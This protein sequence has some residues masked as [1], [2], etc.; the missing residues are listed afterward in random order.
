MPVSGLVG[1]EPQQQQ[2]RAHLREM[3]GGRVQG[4]CITGPPG[5]GK[6]ALAEWFVGEARAAGVVT[7]WTKTWELGGAPP[8][9]P[10]AQMLRT[11]AD[12]LPE[13]ATSA[14]ARLAELAHL[15]PEWG[16][17]GAELPSPER[18]PHA[19]FALFDAVSRCIADLAD[20]SPLLLVLDDAHAA[21]PETLRV[22][23][24]ALSSWQQRP[25]GFV[26]TLRSVDARTPAASLA[27]L[28]ELERHCA[29][30]VVGPLA[31]EAAADLFEARLG[32]RREQVDH[33]GDLVARAGGNPLFILGL[34][35]AAATGADASSLPRTVQTVI[36]RRL[37]ALPEATRVALGLLALIRDGA[38]CSW[39]AGSLAETEAGL[40]ARL[41]P[42]IA[43]EVVRVD[44]EGR[45]GFVHDLFAEAMSVRTPSE[46]RRSLA[47]AAAAAWERLGPEH[48]GNY[49]G[50]LA[51]LNFEVGEPRHVTRGVEHA[52]HGATQ[53]AH[54]L[55]FAAAAELYDA[56]VRHMPRG[57]DKRGAQLEL[58]RMALR[59]GR[60]A[61]AREVFEVL[62]DEARDA[63]EIER[64][65]RA[66]LGFAR[67]FEFGAA[68]EARLARLQA[69]LDVVDDT[70]LEAALVS[71]LAFGVQP[72]GQEAQR[73]RESLLG[74]ARALSRG[75][76][77][78]AD[79]LEATVARFVIEWSATRL[80]ARVEMIREVEALLP[81]LREASARLTAHRWRVNLWLERGAGLEA[82]AAI[83]DYSA[84]AE[85]LRS[86]QVRMNAAL[87]RAIVLQLAGQ[88][89]PLE[90]ELDALDRLGRLARD[91]Q[92]ETYVAL[93]RVLRNRE[94]ED[95]DAAERDL[96]AVAA[97]SRWWGEFAG[98]GLFGAVVRLWSGRVSE[99]RAEYERWRR[100]DFA[101]P[102]YW[103]LVQ[104]LA[105]LAELALGLDDLDGAAKIYARLLPFASH[106]AQCGIG[107]PLG[108]AAHHLGRIA[109]AR[110]D[111]GVAVGHF[112][113]AV[114][115]NE[116]M[117]ADYW[118][119]QS[120]LELVRARARARG[121]GAAIADGVDRG[122]VRRVWREAQTLGWT[123][124][125][126]FAEQLAEAL[127]VELGDPATGASPPTPRALTSTTPAGAG[128]RAS[129][130]RT[131]VFRRDG[132]VWVVGLDGEATRVTDAR[133]LA[134]LHVLLR[135]P[136][137]ER[138]A[139]D[140]AFP[141]GAPASGDAGPLLDA[142]ARAAYRERAQDLQATLREAEAHDDWARAERAQA[143][144]EALTDE[145]TRAVGR[146][147]RERK[148]G[149]TAERARVAVTQAIRRA[150]KTLGRHAPGLA[151]HLEASVRTGSVCTYQPEILVDWET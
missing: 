132:Q 140:L 124:T 97:S 88:F 144:L 103:C 3:L 48:R 135:E 59:A 83:R 27:P 13:A 72:R 6:S 34:A 145:L 108:S 54:A 67:S 94:L 7:V 28:A 4:V 8:F 142:R 15:V 26:A 37:D 98:P 58:G 70:G 41:R 73:M 105:L 77:S 96:L 133:G 57:P 110:G 87:R 71:E 112:E 11:L 80:D 141:E 19:Q 82:R 38:T 76:S 123:R 93:G 23:A 81:E 62:I 14:R 69:A 35:D 39:L 56:A 102:D 16:S 99:A 114:A 42:A 61:F 118:V 131:G 45:V 32:R 125:V 148:A 101:L 24:Y 66:S 18:G 21:D 31:P 130:G 113:Q 25:I 138:L 75:G 10:W 51:R 134:Y 40:L 111:A 121:P 43:D 107:F 146:G 106:Q 104:G 127:A 74:R 5:I 55:D 64:M 137:R 128:P 22:A 147:G 47:A 117:L 119:A 33:E 86:P 151:A 17:T 91:P 52:L 149:S 30:L 2:L 122:L 109:A 150:L 65:V 9:W 100:A 143:E 49:P 139:V 46:R 120:R 84:T 85:L 12:A 36:D 116:R 78:S 79:R 60:P 95:R 44:A 126:A 50:S 53:A 1:R 63:G 90:V 29:R 92:V 115:A 20:A 136:G 129:A 89:A 68:S